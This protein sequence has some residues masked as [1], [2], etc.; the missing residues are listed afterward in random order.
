MTSLQNSNNHLSIFRWIN[1]F[2]ET[3]EAIENHAWEL[4]S[5]YSAN[6][7]NLADRRSS[8][9]AYWELRGTHVGIMK[10]RN[11]FINHIKPSI[12]EMHDAAAI[13][14]TVLSWLKTYQLDEF[15]SEEYGRCCLK[16]LTKIIE[17]L[18]WAIEQGDPQSLLDSKWRFLI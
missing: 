13:K 3:L 12:N 8:L 15:L 11:D 14:K 6:I 16:R 2:E 17:E 10:L 18:M 4:T 7:L 9:L 5:R 1:A